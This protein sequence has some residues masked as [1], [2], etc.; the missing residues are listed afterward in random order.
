[1][2]HVRDLRIHLE[3]PGPWII[4]VP[5]A[6]RVIA[7]TDLS[8][9]VVVVDLDSNVVTCGN[10]SP[11]A[12]TTGAPRDKARRRL[13]GA[14]GNVGSYFSVPLSIVEAF[15]NGR[16]KPFSEVEIDGERRG[17]ER[18]GPDPAWQVSAN[19]AIDHSWD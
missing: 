8:P 11:S 16:F 13:E 19:I 9:E 5:S 14:I 6:S 3:D 18:L 12:V 17:V 1:M 4:G 15:P 10:P 2:S 7:L